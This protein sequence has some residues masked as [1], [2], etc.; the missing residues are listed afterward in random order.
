M[1]EPEVFQTKAASAFLATRPRGALKRSPSLLEK[2]RT[3]GADDPR[4]K[5]PDY[6]RDERGICFYRR[7]DLER[8]AEERLARLQFRAPAKQPANFRSRRGADQA[9]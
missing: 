8:Y 9:A 5:G 3:R 4:D 1:A 6:Y 7:I 2:F